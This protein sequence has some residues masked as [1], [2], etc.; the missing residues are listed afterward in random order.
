VLILLE[1]G[2]FALLKDMVAS[3]LPREMQ[4][5][6]KESGWED[7]FS[8]LFDSGFSG[9]RGCSFCYSWTVKRG[10]HLD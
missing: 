2:G 1:F 4:K 9:R 6:R 5:I 10:T 8:W 7:A 3:F